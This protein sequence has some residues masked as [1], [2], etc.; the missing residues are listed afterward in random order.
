MRARQADGCV[1]ATATLD[2]GLLARVAAELPMVLINRRVTSHGIPAVV[3]DDHSGVRQA[4][5]HLAALGH[6]RIAHVAGPQWASTGAA[7]HAAF[8]DTLKAVGLEAPTPR[9]SASRMASRRSRAPGRCSSCSTPAP[10]S[11][12]SSR[13]TTWW[14]SAATTRSPS[15]A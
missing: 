1:A 2:D 10:S 8:F 13:A 3:A 9:R 4:V 6:E 12:R 14:P 7:R 11:P 15:A 5:E